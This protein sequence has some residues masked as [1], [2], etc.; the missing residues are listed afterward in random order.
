MLRKWV[1]VWMM[2]LLLALGACKTIENS[3]SL[4]SREP[5]VDMY[6]GGP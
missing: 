3:I 6:G 2:A 1:G 5:E 4:G